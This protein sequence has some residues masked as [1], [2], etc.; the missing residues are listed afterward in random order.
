VQPPEKKIWFPA[1]RHGWGWGIPTCWQGWA[2]IIAFYLLLGV[3]A[4]LLLPR[5][6][7]RF[8]FSCIVLSAA[9]VAVGCLKGEKPRWRW[10]NEKN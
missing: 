10:G 6:P 2:V 5:H 7:A 4:V 8:V 9:L 3:A 1:K